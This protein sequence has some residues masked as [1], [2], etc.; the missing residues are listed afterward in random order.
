MAGNT[1]QRQTYLRPLVALTLILVLLPLALGASAR[2]APAVDTPVSGPI[3]SD[4]TWTL[5]NSPYLATT[6]VQVMAGVTLTIQAGVVVKFNTDKLLQ[7][8]GTLVARGTAL[9]PITF[10]SS[11]A[12]PQPGD[13]GN[14]Q[15]TDSSVDAVFDGGGAYVGGSILEYCTVEYGGGSSMPPTPAPAPTPTPKVVD[16][17]LPLL[18][19]TADQDRAE[20]SVYGTIQADAAAPLIAHCTVRHNGR[21]GIYAVATEVSPVTIRDNV[22]SGNSGGYGGG[23][24]TYYGTVTGNTIRD[25]AGGYGGIYAGYST[26]AGNA[27][28]GNSAT[29]VGGGIYADESMVI[30]NTV[31]GNLAG[32]GGGI[33]ANHSTV[34][35][36]TVSG[37]SATDY[38]SGDGGGIYAD[39][40]ST[41]TAN[42]V[43]GNSAD[44]AG[45]GIYTMYS[46]TTT[47]NIVSG[48][49]AT[50]AGGG[51]YAGGSAVMSNTITA[52]SVSQDGQGAGVYYGAYY[53]VSDFLYNTIVG[54][55]APS[56]IIGGIAIVGSPQF[57][58]N[59]LYGNSPYDV[60]VASYYYGAVADISSTNNYWGTTAS[61][62]ILDHV[63]DWYDNANRG[64]LLFIPYLHGLD[65][66]APVPPPQ[67][68][69]GVA[70]AGAVASTWDAVP[71]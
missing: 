46:S 66:Q 39:W 60:V 6:N 61:V 54:N 27:V 14:I 26:V 21:G 43:S 5:A 69:Q 23:V 53:G 63:Y 42:I 45:G 18:G 40:N 70:G 47:G 58:Y 56:G 67:H 55:T 17:V 51:I 13:W 34:A 31:S 37:N 3:L 16:G 7:V 64:R 12:S 36:N 8:D 4:T 59:N 44:N 2:A 52:N 71:G 49:W 25:N 10:T 30:S 33:Y 38:Y 9:A 50:H 22:I 35:G 11:Q 20:A 62:D 15:F 28:S 29:Y 65:P 32:N 48:N 1:G 19:P 57:H 41:V 24:L 68:L